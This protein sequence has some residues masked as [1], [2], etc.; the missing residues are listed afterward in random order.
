MT[1]AGGGGAFQPTWSPDGARLAYVSD[2]SGPFE[3]SVPSTPTGRRATPDARATRPCGVLAPLLPRW[4]PGCSSP[5]ARATIA[6]A[7]SPPSASTNPPARD[8][9]QQRDVVQRRQPFPG[10][11]ATGV[12]ALARRRGHVGDLR[13]TGR[14]E[15]ERR[16]TRPALLAFAPEWR[17][18]GG[19]IAFA[20]DLYGDRP[21][22][23]IYTISANGA[24]VVRVTH[25]PFPSTDG[26]QLC[27]RG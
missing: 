18:D 2:A 4:S 8:H 12:P 1:R 11:L 27:P 17:P 21:F 14:R 23:S 6:T 19:R 25:P 3:I 5:T 26:A 9:A 13:G 10:R 22:G 24:D 16:V 15:R 7:E 20:S